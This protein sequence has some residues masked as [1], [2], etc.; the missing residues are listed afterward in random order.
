MHSASGW[1]RV[2]SRLVLRLRWASRDCVKAAWL[3]LWWTDIA[4][5]RENWVGPIALE[6]IQ[7]VHVDGIIVLN[8]GTFPSYSG[9]SL[10][11]I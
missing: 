5:L 7:A 6:G 10:C 2:M 1:W 11:I 3:F 4:F 8:Y 9:V